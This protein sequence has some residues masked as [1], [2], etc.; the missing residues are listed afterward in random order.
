MLWVRCVLL[1]ACKRDVCLAA[2]SLIS[3]I[4]GLLPGETGGQLLTQYAL[5]W[6]T[7]AESMSKTHMISTALLVM[8]SQQGLSPEHQLTLSKIL[9][10]DRRCRAGDTAVCGPPAG[11]VLIDLPLS[12][13]HQHKSVQV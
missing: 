2:W 5:R 4:I 7:Q 12:C 11:H 8:Q 9:D 3:E 1:P 6:H 10:Q 13:L